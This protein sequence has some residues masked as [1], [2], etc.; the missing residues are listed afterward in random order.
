MSSLRHVTVEFVFIPS[1]MKFIIN[2]NIFYRREYHDQIA[3]RRTCLTY[4]LTTKLGYC[5]VEC[6]LFSSTGLITV[7][8]KLE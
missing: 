5:P 7:I 2:N 3:Q 8:K 1:D 4:D 6:W